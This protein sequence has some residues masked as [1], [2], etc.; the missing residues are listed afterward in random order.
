MREGIYSWM[1]NLAVYY[2]LLTAAVNFMPDEK[3]AGY[4]RYFMGLVLITMLCTPVFAILGKGEEVWDSFQG[5]LQEERALQEQY[6]PQEL[7]ESLLRQGYEEAAAREIAGR[8]SGILGENVAVQVYFQNHVEE[9]IARVCISV[10]G[11]GSEQKEAAVKGELESNYEIRE[12][13]VELIFGEYDG[14][15][16]DR[17][18]SSGTAAGSD[19]TSHRWQ[20]E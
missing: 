4:L 13:Q 8:L 6:M 7:Q 11:S 1:R 15:A 3:Y 10:E 9:G 20:G 18:P 17:P 5:Y 2:L 14:K 19:G 16:M 12:E